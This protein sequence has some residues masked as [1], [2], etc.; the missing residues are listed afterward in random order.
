MSSL[1]LMENSRQRKQRQ[2]VRHGNQSGTRSLQCKQIQLLTAKNVLANALIYLI[3][4]DEQYILFWVMS[5]ESGLESQG[6][7]R[8]AIF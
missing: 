5:N 2:F 8:Q 7:A 3:L 4:S 6:N 1:L